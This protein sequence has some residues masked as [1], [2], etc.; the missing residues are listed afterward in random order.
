MT[1][2]RGSVWD[3]FALLCFALLCF[4][5]PRSHSSDGAAE[6]K[7]R[8]RALAAPFES[9]IRGGCRSDLMVNVR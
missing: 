4:A 9:D 1:M 3:C 2:W 8:G 7:E 6:S 5:P